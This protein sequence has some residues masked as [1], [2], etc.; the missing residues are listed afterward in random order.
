MFIRIILLVL[1]SVHFALLARPSDI[2]TTLIG[3][4]QR[5]PSTQGCIEC[6]QMAASAWDKELNT[7]YNKLRSDLNDSAKASLKTSQLAWIKF[8][9]SEIHFIQSHYSTLPG[10]LYRQSMQEH[11]IALTRVRALQLLE[12]LSETKESKTGP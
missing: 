5:N 9:D 8:R 6:L 2:D 12:Y 3:C 11:M 1:A 7:T 10:T 4:E